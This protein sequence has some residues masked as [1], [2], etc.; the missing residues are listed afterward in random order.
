[1]A[2]NQNIALNPTKINGVCGRLLCC[3][4]YEDDVYMEAR[5][6]L[7]NVGSTVKTK[8]GDGVVR[9][10]DILNRKYTALVNNELVDVDLN[11]RD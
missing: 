11:E 5:K 3:L 8:K 4:K 6:G 9:S 1:M 2:K 10:V 7:P